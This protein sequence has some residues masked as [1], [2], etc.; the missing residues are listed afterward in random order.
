MPG[1]R[2]RYLAVAAVIAMPGSLQSAPIVYTTV[3]RGAHES[4]PVI[5]DGVGLGIVTL[6]AGNFTMR[7]QT[8]FFGLTGNVT[9]A[10]VHCCTAEPGTGNVGAAT[11]VPTFPDFPSGDTSGFYDRTFDMLQAASWNDAFVTNN[12]G[13]LLNAFASLKTGLEGGSAYLN[14][15]SMFAPGGEIRGFLRRTY[16]DAIFTDGFEFE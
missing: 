12:G 11:T 5:S 1:L 4:P 14:I 9:V 13:D 2:F 3:L 7:V 16:P 8:A 10:H 6:D 15:H